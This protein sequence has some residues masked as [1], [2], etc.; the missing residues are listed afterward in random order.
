[1]SERREFAAPAQS[2]GPIPAY[3]VIEWNEPVDASVY[4]FDEK[5]RTISKE[6]VKKSGGYMV[7][8]PRGHSIF[9]DDL[10]ALEAA[11]LGEVVPLINMKHGETE[12]NKDHENPLGTVQRKIA[13]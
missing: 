2:E 8:F 6:E 4:R 1:M 13:K 12:A 5:S 10:A 7:M 11:G 9:Y 3:V